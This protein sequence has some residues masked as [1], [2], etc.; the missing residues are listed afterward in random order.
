MAL[1]RECYG[2]FGDLVD[3]GDRCRGHRY[4]VVSLLALVYVGDGPVVLATDHRDSH[5]YRSS[6]GCGGSHCCVRGWCRGDVNYLLRR[7]GDYGARCDAH[8]D[9]MLRCFACDGQY[10]GRRVVLAVF[11]LVLLF[12]FDLV[13]AA[14]ALSVA[15]AID[16]RQY[17]DRSHTA[18]GM[19]IHSDANLLA[20]QCE[21]L[22]LAMVVAHGYR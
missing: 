18:M 21:R 17:V 12:R 8:Y 13:V 22:S 5:V 6:A 1:L 15:V 14:F 3:D 11:G 7:L 20:V 9:E 4:S 19:G 16:R 2:D 10:R